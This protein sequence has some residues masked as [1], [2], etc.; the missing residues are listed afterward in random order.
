MVPELKEF[1]AVDAASFRT[2]MGVVCSQV[3]IATTLVDGMPHGTT[4]TAFASL[5]L[6]P[7]LISVALDERSQL[8]RQ[9]R[10]SQRIGINLL[11][12]GQEELAVRCAGKEPDKFS[13]AAWSLSEGLPR[14]DDVAGWLACEV[15]QEILLGDHV[16]IV[17]RVI[18]GAVSGSAQAPLVYAGRA[19]GTHSD[20]LGRSPGQDQ[21]L[22]YEPLDR[23][24][25]WT[26]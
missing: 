2:V 21:L 19:F 23:W 8:L 11:A 18:A 4:I 7:P 25:N 20:W 14:I 17:A 5:S 24:A 10:L 16:L 26:N 15:L 22:P 1:T 12:R 3:V 13:S 6:D 9:L